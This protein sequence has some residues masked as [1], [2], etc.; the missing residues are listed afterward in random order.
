MEPES[1]RLRDVQIVAEP[2]TP[3]L[4]RLLAY[5]DARRGTAFAPSRHAIDPSA[6]KTDLP[7][8]FMLDVLQDGADYRYRLVGTEVV[9][10]SGRDVT[11]RTFS[12]LYGDEPPVLAQ[13]LAI[14]RKVL[15]TRG[16]VYAQGQVFWLADR[17]Y[18]EF[19]AGYFPL[20]RD[21]THID[22]ILCEVSFP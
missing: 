10:F 13:A 22:I 18:R 21:G 14:F 17:G 1:P 6:L 8:L 4:R 7:N 16:P 15:S 5:W 11:G 2:R 20:S 19:E 3:A 12:E 9:A